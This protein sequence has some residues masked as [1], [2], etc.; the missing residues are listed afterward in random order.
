MIAARGSAESS[1]T[2]C[3]AQLSRG[4]G[5]RYPVGM[6]LSNVLWVALGGAVGS[7]ARYLVSVSA[8]KWFGPEWPVGTLVVN[9]V[10]SCLLGALLQLFLASEGVHPGARLMLTTG[11]MGG[12]TTYSTF[13]YELLLMLESGRSSAAGAYLVATVA[14]CLLAGALGVFT[15]RWIGA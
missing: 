3:R 9:I 8:L 4:D 11:M 15:V 12:F 7:S 14:G 5:L 2:E 10:G 13:N 1:R 6:L